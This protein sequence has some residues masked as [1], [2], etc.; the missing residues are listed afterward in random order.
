LKVVN[1]TPAPAVVGGATLKPSLLAAAGV[2]V[3]A[4]VGD[5]A[6]PAPEEVSVAVKVHE[7]PVLI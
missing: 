4:A 1:A 2:T 5:D 7:V 6:P 3:M